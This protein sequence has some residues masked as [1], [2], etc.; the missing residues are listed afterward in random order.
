[1]RPKGI[2]A[3]EIRRELQQY[4]DHEIILVKVYPNGD[5]SFVPVDDPINESLADI[6]KRYPGTDKGTKHTYLETYEEYF[7]PIRQGAA[8]VLELGVDT[9]HSLLLWR[10]YFP[11]AEIFGADRV[12]MP[13][14]LR[15]QRRIR[16]F[17]VDLND[18]DEI[19]ELREH[20]YDVVIDDASHELEQQLANFDLLQPCLAPGGLYIIEDVVPDSIEYFPEFVVVDLRHLRNNRKVHRYDNI[21]LVYRNEY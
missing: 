3:G 12:P 5:V 19:H 11:C 14:I 16:Y 6:A 7:A 9:G 20:T 21:L 15:D 18:L 4:A 2:Q 1:M 10:D 17:Q 8:S 13:E